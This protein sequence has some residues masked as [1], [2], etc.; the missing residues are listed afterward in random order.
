MIMNHLVEVDHLRKK[1][2]VNEE[3]EEEDETFRLERSAK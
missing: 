2:L 1:H 3:E